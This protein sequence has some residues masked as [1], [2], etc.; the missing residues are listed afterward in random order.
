MVWGKKK[1]KKSFPSSAM[2]TAAKFLKL[3]EDIVRHLSNPA[4]ESLIT[5]RN[6]TG[7]V[8]PAVLTFVSA[9]W[10]ID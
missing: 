3:S 8:A 10:R 2:D 5:F 6:T 1:K 7:T 9:P 4:N